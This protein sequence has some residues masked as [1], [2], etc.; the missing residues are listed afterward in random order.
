MRND[1]PKMKLLYIGSMLI[2]AANLLRIANI[3]FIPEE[4]SHFLS[5]MGIG[6]ILTAAIFLIIAP[7]TSKQI[8]SWKKSF[9]NLLLHRFLKN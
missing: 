3:A 5:G 8:K 2:L 6:L 9:T 4:L 7:R 1:N